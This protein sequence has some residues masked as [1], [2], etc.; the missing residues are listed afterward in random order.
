MAQCL[1]RWIPNPGVAGSKPLVGSKFDVA[2]HHPEVDQMSP[3]ILGLT[4]K[5][6]LSPRQ[7]HCSLEKV[8]NP[9]IKRGQKVF[10][11]PEFFIQIGYIREMFPAHISHN[12]SIKKFLINVI[13]YQLTKFYYHTLVTYQ[14]IQSNNIF[15]KHITL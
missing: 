3:S 4:V 15:L 12:S 6:K 9:S 10:F 11:F 2:F 13:L 14:V 1:G 5:S 7:W 8:E